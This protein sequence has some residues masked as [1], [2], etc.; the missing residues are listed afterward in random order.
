VSQHTM[1][2]SSG[3]GTSSPADTV[4]EASGCFDQ[5]D[6]EMDESL[7][8]PVAAGDVAWLRRMIGAAG[9]RL[10]IRGGR[11]SIVL[12]G[13]EVMADLHE[14]FSGDPSTTDVLTFDLRA[15]GER[16]IEGEVYVGVEEGRRRAAELGH[17]ARLEWLLYAVHG[18]LHLMGYD[19]HEP[20]DW[21]RMHDAEDR[22]LEALG[23]GAV[24]DRGGERAAGAK[25]HA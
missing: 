13:D 5:L 18:L 14:R 7:G 22:L 4:G 19:D 11:L 12:V 8:P 23:V 9:E 16:R 10:G 3:S 1:D 15:E 24:F 20:A 2:A 17:E 6:I 21:A 25:S